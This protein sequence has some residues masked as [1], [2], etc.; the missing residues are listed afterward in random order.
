MTTSNHILAGT[1]IALTVKTPLLV[2]PLAFMSHFLLDA[3]PHY[4]YEGSGYSEA[5][6]HKLTYVMEALGAIGIL[7]LAASGAL[8]WS[9]VLL[10]AFFAVLP[11][12]EWLY[13]YFLFERK[14][15]EPP[16]TFLTDFHRKIQWCER[17]WGII[18]EVIFFVLGYAL[19]LNIMK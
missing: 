6:R 4:G 2:L 16:K 17:S 3:L 10:A 7:L 13:R 5:F 15:L 18:P 11:D 9:L 1:L 12:F 8:G 14:G 19:L